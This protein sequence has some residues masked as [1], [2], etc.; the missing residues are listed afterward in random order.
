[1]KA[2]SYIKLQVKYGGQF[3]ALYKGKVIAKSKTSKGLF[4]KI[5]PKLGDPHLLIQHIDPKDAVC[6]YR[7]SSLH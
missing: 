1:M 2:T 4:K 5:A 7:V 6:V 3:I